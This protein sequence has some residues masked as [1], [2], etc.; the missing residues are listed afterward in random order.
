MIFSPTFVMNFTLIMWEIKQISSN[1]INPPPLSLFHSSYIFFLAESRTHPSCPPDFDWAH[2]THCFSPAAD[3]RP[4]F[5]FR[6]KKISGILIAGDG[7]SHTSSGSAAVSIHGISI[8]GDFPSRGGRSR[9][10]RGAACWNFP[11]ECVLISPLLVSNSV[12]NM[13]D[14]V[15]AGAIL[16]QRRRPEL[17]QRLPMH[18]SGICSVVVRVE[19]FHV[20]KQC[21]RA[22]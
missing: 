11:R 6:G 1:N 12:A 9:I 8:P 21:E 4:R 2:V 5:F 22:L 7:V 15:N 20:L 18:E 14:L 13:R 16:I 10:T 19:V 3:L 17:H